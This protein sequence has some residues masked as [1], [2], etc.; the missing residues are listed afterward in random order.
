MTHER[1][2]GCG[3]LLSDESG[4][5]GEVVSFGADEFAAGEQGAGD[6]GPGG[7]GGAR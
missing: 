6:G 7:G 2:W 5:E 4:E 1:R 3:C